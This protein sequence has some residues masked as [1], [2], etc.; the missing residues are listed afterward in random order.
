MY[1]HT[2]IFYT[3]LLYKN[4]RVLLAATSKGLCFLGTDHATI[5]DLT[6]YCKKRYSQFSISP[7]KEEL[8]DYIIELT[9]YF[10]GIRTSFTIPFDI[11]GT[12]FQTDVWE[13]LRRIPYGK[14]MCY[15]DIAT[16]IQNPKSTRAV[17]VAIGKNPLSIV[18]PCHRVLGKDGSLTGFSGGLDVKEKL[19]SHE[20]ISYKI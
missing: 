19:L 6:I 18:I 5:E 13:A 12:T 14:T 10:D 7:S 15:S 3:E 17:G 20:G 11:V 4:W 9:E 2:E 8:K 16:L 1:M